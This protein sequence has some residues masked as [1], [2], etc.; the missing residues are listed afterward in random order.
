[1]SSCLA[2]V[3]TRAPVPHSARMVPHIMAR[4]GVNLGSSLRGG[5]QAGRQ[6]G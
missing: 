1:M 6:A 3:A 5:G 2:V 4:P